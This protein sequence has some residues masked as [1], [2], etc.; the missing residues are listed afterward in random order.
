MF[1]QDKH[2]RIRLVVLFV[3]LLLIAVILKVFYIQV[4][5]YQKLN[6]LANDLWQRNLPITPD[7]GLILDRNGKVLASNI[8]TTSLYLVPN[9]IKNK[10]EV[11]KTLSE[12]LEVPYD[13]MYKHVSK[14]TS[15]ER[16]HPEGRQLS[17]E[18]ADKI[19]SYNYDGIY[20][21]K[22]AKRYYP[23][24]DLLSHVLGYVGIDN[25]GLSGLELKY[26]EELTGTS[27][28]IKYYS[29][30]KGNRLNKAEEYKEAISGNN[31][32]L[33]IDLDLQ[34]SV[35]RELDNAVA[36]YNP[37]HALAIAINPKTG[38]ILAMA[39]RPSYNPNEY[40]T[41][42]QE[43][44]SRNLPIWMTYEPGSTMKITTISAAIN[45][46]VVNLFTDTFFDSGS[47]NV[48]GATIHCWKSG[49]HGAQTFLNVV[50]NSCNPGFVN[51]GFRLGKEKLF[52]YIKDFGFGEKTGIDL[53]GEAKGILF[54]LDRVGNVELATTAFGQGISV[55]PIQQVRSVSAAVNGGILYQP[56]IVKR[57][58]NA[59]TKE[60]ISEVNPTVI[61][62]VITEESS[63]LVRFALENV[64]AHGSGRNAYIENYRIGGK[65]GTAQKVNNG[66]YMVGNYILSFIGFLPAD[67][68]EIVLYVA[69]DNPK[70]VTQYGG[71]V[72]APIA[73]AIFSSYIEMNNVPKSKD[74]IPKTYNWLDT[75][76][77]ILPNV[78]G[79]T[80][81]E[82]N[83]ILKD[84]KI[85]YSGEGNKVI[86]QS[87]EPE[88]YVSDDSTVK[89]MLGD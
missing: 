86:Y 38:E 82:A 8:T 51:L 43:V 67:D 25:Q 15:I 88:Y 83:N 42:T 58:E 61:R 46:G 30:A 35:E 23:Y 47:I 76:Y 26:N 48:D 79:K 66:R 39:S 29:D 59:T 44:L 34:Q 80:I 70:G 74:T 19:N 50:E 6:S 64:V 57:V 14:R 53:T 89:L 69:V 9:Q 7:R 20:L 10:E 21:L 63:K 12:I 54:D 81:K 77:S 11:A 62:Q 5:Q 85:E 65:T 73:K 37:E 36:K 2:F 68:P 55:T 72:A 1:Y 52:K 24:N 75:K 56:Y 17:F 16:V 71:V 87:P 32:Y 13:E 84:Y 3:T 4:F 40:Q 78:I 45:E 28:S 41:Y 33:T 31:V 18:I 27:G 22:E 49:G 60:T